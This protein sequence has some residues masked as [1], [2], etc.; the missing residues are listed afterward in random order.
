MDKVKTRSN[1]PRLKRWALMAAG[2]VLLIAAAF[3]VSSTDFGVKRVKLSQVS[4]DTVQ[5]GRLDIKVSANGELKS[6]NLEQLTA[7]VPGR[8][9]KIHVRP[10]TRVE[11]GQ[12]ITELSN[13]QIVASAE[14]A[15][16]VW[17][18]ALREKKAT[19]ADLQGRLLL[20]ESVAVQA[21]FNLERARVQLES[22]ASVADQGIISKNDYRRSKLNA[23]Q[24]E[25]LYTIE[26]SRTKRIRD[27]ISVQV[28]VSES[29]VAQVARALERASNEVA[30][31][32]IKA[33]IKGIVQAVDLEVGQQVQAGTQ[34]GRLAQEDDLYA[35]LKVAAREAGEIRV[36]QEVTVDTRNGVV[37]GKVSRI[38]PGVT[39]GAVIVDVELLGPLPSGAR[40]QLQVEGTIYIVQLPDTLFVGKPAYVKADAEVSVFRLD[41]SGRYAERMTVK[42]GKV[43]LTQVQVLEGLRPGD[44]IITS[45]TDKWS[46]QARILLV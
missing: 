36:G 32:K 3:Y 29:R 11:A 2:A 5:Q 25:E 31:L 17:E 27:N 23:Q 12:L 28:S 22:D 20:Q 6:R 10:G 37:K 4:I 14:E 35:E 26:I 24:A 43:S 8:V 18:G 19:Q 16:S 41:A 33:G 15:R 21:K 38:D 13:P 34:V 1:S 30:N 7:Q 40:P 45:E 9:E 39:Q 42:V 44:R 46:D